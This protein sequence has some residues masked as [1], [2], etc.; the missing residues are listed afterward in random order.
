MIEDRAQRSGWDGRKGPE[1]GRDGGRDRR[2]LHTIRI[3]VLLRLAHS[4]TLTIFST[5]KPVG[6]AKCLREGICHRALIIYS[7]HKNI[8]WLLPYP[9][10][11]INL[12]LSMTRIFSTFPIRCFLSHQKIRNTAKVIKFL[13]SAANIKQLCVT[14]EA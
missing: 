12:H 7:F 8:L 2:A 10:F 4:G 1:G 5:S 3:Y 11:I 14:N 13:S 9:N 6:F